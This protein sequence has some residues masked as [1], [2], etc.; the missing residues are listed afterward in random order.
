MFEFLKGKRTNLT[1][2]VGLIALPLIDKLTGFD[3]GGLISKLI[4]KACDAELCL[5]V[6]KEAGLATQNIYLAAVA[7]LVVYFRA[8]AGK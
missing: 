5:T 4:T 8:Q 2:I 7:A 1:A 6:A 3:A